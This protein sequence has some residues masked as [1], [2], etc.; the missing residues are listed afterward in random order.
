MVRR[1]RMHRAGTAARVYRELFDLGVS[2]LY[3]DDYR[4]HRR[5]FDHLDRETVRTWP[6]IAAVMMRRKGGNEDQGTDTH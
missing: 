4:K 2:G 3:T 6:R 5:I 1:N